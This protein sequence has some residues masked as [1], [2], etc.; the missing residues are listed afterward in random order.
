MYIICCVHKLAA[1]AA[2]SVTQ[3]RAWRWRVTGWVYLGRPNTK[4]KKLFSFYFWYKISKVR[5][6]FRPFLVNSASQAAVATRHC[7]F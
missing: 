6:I 7:S 3:H 5:Q 2:D 1:G 4:R